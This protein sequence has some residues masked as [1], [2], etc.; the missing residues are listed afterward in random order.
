MRLK[1]QAG[2]AKQG[3]GKEEISFPRA[4]GIAEKKMDK[5]SNT[6]ALLQVWKKSYFTK[7]NTHS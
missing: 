7:L 1:L 4:A 2:N 5:L 3:L 6:P